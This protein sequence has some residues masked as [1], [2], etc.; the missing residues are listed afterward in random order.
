[1][2]LQIL[3]KLLTHLKFFKNDF[4]VNIQKIKQKLTRIEI[5]MTKTTI[6]VKNYAFIISTKNEHNVRK[7]TTMKNLTIKQKNN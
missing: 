3:C 7:T 1:M 2:L 4:R 5:N 6:I